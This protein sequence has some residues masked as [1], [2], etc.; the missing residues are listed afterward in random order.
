MAF[1]RVLTE[2]IAQLSYLIGDDR[3]ATAAVIDPRPDCEIYLELARKLGLGI[4]HI[5]ETHIHADFL[6]GARE[7]ADRLGLDPWAVHVSREGQAEYG[8]DHHPVRDGDAFEFGSVLLTARYTP[9]HTPEHLSYLVAEKERP[10]AP[11]GIFTGDSLF[12]G[13]AGRPDLLG[14]RQTDELARRLFY[15][16]RDF[17]LRQ[18][19]GLMIFPCHGAGSACGA[20]IGDRPMS[21][22]GF[23]RRFNPFLQYDDLDEFTDFVRQS[24]PPE[25]AYYQRLKKE[26][27]NGP[28]ILGGLPPAPGLPPHRFQA[29]IERDAAVLVDTREMLA[30]GGGHIAGAVNIGAREELASWAGQMLD[31]DRPILLVLEREIM[32][33]WV[34]RQLLRVGFRRYAGYLAG[35]MKAWENAGL[36]LKKAPQMTVH[37]LKERPPEMQ[38]LDVRSPSEFASGRIPGA[39]HFYVADMRD[40]HDGIDGL[41][42][43]RPVAAYCGSGYRASIAAS[44]LQRL[45]FEDV[46]NVPGSWQAWTNSKYPVEK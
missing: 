18:D 28:E 21:T 6:S 38:V 39:R 20:D 22:I 16:L 13:S 43:H 3:S 2:G 14:G 29:E 11:W 44:L 33:P 7:L 12:A 30:F 32:L 26:N 8:F 46:R 19:D 45:G 15:T 27:A 34:L 1:E 24:A 4:T 41:D 17:Y 35:G 31:H 42:K 40:A 9:G 36:P 10:Q 23:E 5:F 25:P 37:E